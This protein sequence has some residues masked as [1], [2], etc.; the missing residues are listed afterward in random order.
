MRMNTKLALLA[1]A[2]LLVLHT[3]APF[4]QSGYDLFQKALAAE[5]ADGNLQQAIELYQ[6]VAR[7]F[8]SDR[9]LAA[10]ALVR[11]ADCYTK[12]GNAQARSIYERVA[13]EYPEQ[14]A[15][16]QEAR[17]HLQAQGPPRSSV[18]GDRLVWGPGR[19][20]DLFGTVSPDGRF[21]TYVDWFGAGNVVVRDLLTGGDRALTNN[22]RSGEH[23]YA[24][25]S[26][27]SR[28]GDQVAYAWA[29]LEVV[30]AGEE[31]RIV[32]FDGTAAASRLLLP[33]NGRDGFRPFDWSPDGRWIALLIS[34]EDQ[35]SQ[36]AVVNTRS[37]ELRVLKSIDWR[38]VNKAVFSPDGRYLAYDLLEGEGVRTQR[39]WVMAVD[40]SRETAV[41]PASTTNALMGWTA[42][43]HLLFANDRSGHLGLWSMR[44]ENGRARDMP[45]LVKPDLSSTWSLGLTRSDALYLWKPA[46][47]EYVAVADFDAAAG[48]IRPAPAPMFQ[49][50]VDSRGRPAWS[51][52]GKRLLYV[53]CNSSGGSNCRIFIRDLEK[54]TTREVPHKL[55]YVS[56][57]RF[58]FDSNTI[59]TQGTDLKGRRAIYLIDATSGSTKLITD[60]PEV[61]FWADW[62]PDG[63]SIYYA[64][65]RPNEPL[66]LFRH[67]IGSDVEAEI[68]RTS[69]CSRGRG[70][71]SPD[72]RTIACTRNDP[73]ARTVTLMVVPLDGS[74]AKALMRVPL[75]EGFYPWQWTPD[76]RAILAHKIVPGGTDE[77]WL[78]PLDGEPRLLHV[79]MRNWSGEPGDF[80]LSPD[81]KRIAFVASAG[82]HGAEVWA[83]E[84][85]LT[86]VGGTR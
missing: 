9:A 72:A 46:G 62:W 35:S 18:R 73:N 41:T 33:L 63:R 39:V 19:E 34:R 40:A 2:G 42:D 67:D 17:T 15:A 65:Q 22:T 52:D 37:G 71:V 6:R 4:A 25:F 76:S 24:D 61:P 79:D 83:L 3:A 8:A 75:P 26:V 53:S 60:K 11:M 82:A 30:S 86:P 58:G 43:G 78:A 12:L 36:L 31:L 28:S 48:E 27:I 64:N 5:R 23:G 85:F 45:V 38:G 13:R 16:V 69:A 81:G 50:F 7:E 59:V 80:D 54:G 66:V 56:Y 1:V 49:A 84:H 21:L 77:L 47:A 14:T 20:V 57:P 29:P 44:V 74:A 68:F 51:V 70:R 10:R 32:P 55:G